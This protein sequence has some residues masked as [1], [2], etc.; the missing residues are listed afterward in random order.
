MNEEYCSQ[1]NPKYFVVF[2]FCLNCGKRC[3]TPLSEPGQL[4][5]IFAQEEW[6]EYPEYLTYE[7]LQ[8]IKSGKINFIAK[9]VKDIFHL[10]YNPL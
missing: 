1:C 9:P 3:H 8:D 5:N 4:P 2:G 6:E 7:Q 10:P